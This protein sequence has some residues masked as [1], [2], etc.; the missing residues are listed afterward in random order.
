MTSEHSVRVKTG[1]STFVDGRRAWVILLDGRLYRV[2]GVSR[3]WPRRLRW[4]RDR[5]G[6]RRVRMPW[7]LGLLLEPAL[8][9]EAVSHTHEGFARAVETERRR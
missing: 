3:P 1:G 4:L 9:D 7:V 2:I 8:G 5:L 6:G